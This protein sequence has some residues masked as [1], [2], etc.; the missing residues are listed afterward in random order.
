[1]ST[2]RTLRSLLLLA[3]MALPGAAAYA[4]SGDRAGWTIEPGTAEPSYA[5][6]EPASTN[7]NIDTVVLACEPGEHGRLL[8]LQLYLTEEGLLAPKGAQAAKT[9]DDP[10]AELSIDGEIFPVTLLFSESYAVLA[11]DQDGMLAKVSD[12]L[13]SAMQ[14]GTTMTLRFDLLAE[15]PSDRPFDGEAVVDLQRPNRGEAIAA[16]RRC[17]NEGRA[18]NLSESPP[19]APW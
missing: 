18:V 8:Q 2:N 9:K 16:M 7:M 4:A 1:V 14:T 13:L 12:H 11:D 19:A 5:M 10:Q 17:A 3:G 6:V 15:R